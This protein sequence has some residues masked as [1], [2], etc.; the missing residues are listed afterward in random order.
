M[1]K[2]QYQACLVIQWSNT[3]ILKLVLNYSCYNTRAQSKSEYTQFCSR[4]KSLSNIF[5]PSVLKNGTSWMLKSEF[6][7]R[8]QIQKI[9]F[10]LF[11]N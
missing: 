4:T 6:S 9:A 5:F 2:V 8:F 7:I 11:Q 1:E 3:K 10:N